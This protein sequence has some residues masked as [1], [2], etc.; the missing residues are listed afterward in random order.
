MERRH[1]HFVPANKFRRKIKLTRSESV[2]LLQRQKDLSDVGPFQHSLNKRPDDAGIKVCANR[3]GTPSSVYSRTTV[4]SPGRKV[5]LPKRP[6][7]G[8]RSNADGAST[9]SSLK[10]ERS[11]SF[12]SKFRCPGDGC[13]SDENDEKLM[14]QWS[15]KSFHDDSDS[16]TTENLSVDDGGDD[17]DTEDDADIE[18][19]L[20][21]TPT[22]TSELADDQDDDDTLYEG[23]GF[24][25]IVLT[26]RAVELIKKGEE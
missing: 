5:Y 23:T 13:T 12:A 3:T 16:S 21:R 11:D 25:M 4:V 6:V 1:L 7:L 19:D 17:E 26:F 20:L 2:V 10:E 22:T 15:K 14:T 24:N 8:R 18:D 9:S